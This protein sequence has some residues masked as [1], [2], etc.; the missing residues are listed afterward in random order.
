MKSITVKILTLIENK[1]LQTD[2]LFKRKELA[3]SSYGQEAV[4]RDLN[5]IS[6]TTEMSNTVL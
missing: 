4:R 6:H 2:N 5:V 3:Y 1:L